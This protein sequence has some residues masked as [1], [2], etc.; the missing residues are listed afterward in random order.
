MRVLAT[1]NPVCEVIAPITVEADHPLL[2]HNRAQ[3][4][5]GAIPPE[6]WPETTR[7]D[8]GWE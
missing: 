8:R 7:A 2:V 1:E 4:E 3:E 5:A 6:S